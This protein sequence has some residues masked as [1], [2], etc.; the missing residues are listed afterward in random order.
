MSFSM[1][2][3]PVPPCDDPA[4]VRTFLTELRERLLHLTYKQLNAPSTHLDHGG[5]GGLADND[6]PQ[7]VR[8]AT[9]TQK[10][11]L[12]AWDSATSAFLRLAVGAASTV[13]T[14]DA[15]AALGLTWTAKDGYA[16][17]LMLGG[18]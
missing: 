6:H 18:M 4:A 14:A 2:I 12:L 11:D 7:Y 9:G 3:Q 17:M 16:K 5:L 8:H 13:L 10:G 15:A 1:E